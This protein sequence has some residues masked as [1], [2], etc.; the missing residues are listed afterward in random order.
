M[1]RGRATAFLAGA[2]ALVAACGPS[3]SSPE[4]GGSTSSASSTDAGLVGCASDPRAQA[5]APNMTKQGEAGVF[6]FVLVSADPAPPAIDQNTWVL[7]VEDGSGNV[8]Q[9]VMLTSVTPFMPDHGHG[10]ST[11]TITPNPDGTFTVSSVYLFMA[12]LW[13]TTVVA[14]ANGEKDSAV[15][16]F[17]IAG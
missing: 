6:T 10:T 7:A 8:V 12:G 1:K 17:C 11:P 15:F 14:Q 3:A 2:A 5:F 13:Q 4:D 9:G 16:S